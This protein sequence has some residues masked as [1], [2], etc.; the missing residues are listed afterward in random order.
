[1]AVIVVLFLSLLCTAR[2]DTTVKIGADEDYELSKALLYARGFRFYTEV[3]N[4]QPLL[5][6][7]IVSSVL[8]HN[9]PSVLGPRMIT[10][11]F[12]LILITSLFVLIRSMSGAFVAVIAILLLIMSPGFIDLSASCMVEIA[13]LAPAVAGLAVLKVMKNSPPKLVMTLGGA[14]FG[15]ALQ[16]KV[17]NLILLIVVAAV[18]WL[19]EVERSTRRIEGQRKKRFRGILDLEYVAPTAL[20]C[21]LFCISLVIVF[22]LINAILPAGSYFLQ[23]NQMWL[24]HFAAPR[25]FEYGSPSQFRFDW[26]ILL[27][28]WDQTIPAS[29]GLYAC[30]RGLRKSTWLI[31]PITWFV[32]ELI[33][34]GIHTP[35]WTAYYIHN[36]IPIAWCA[37]IG[38][39][40]VVQCLRSLKSKALYTVASVFAVAAAMWMAARSYLQISTIRHS[41]QTYNSIILVEINRF[42][43]YTEFMFAEEGAYSFHSGIPFAPRLAVLSLKRYWSGDVTNA[44]VRE[45][46][47]R[48]KPGLIIIGNDTMQR[49]YADL[50]MAEY[51]L[52]Y[53][54]AKH[55]LFARKDIAKRATW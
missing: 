26:T 46:M 3:W 39:A 53:E 18:V 19:T 44:K 40:F 15:F 13:S 41:P 24:A 14:L 7:A 23:L 12:T 36:A 17:I 45:E 16:I 25:S 11:G 48:V 34:F 30:F 38:I 20:N 2:L 28:N 9:S 4:D 47:W 29:V 55:R 8:N 52:V 50:L 31:I 21:A 22:G 33:V 35:W 54:D 27:K 5:H 1:L 49:A 43:P 51:S 32:L 37:A 10:L 42:K 6:T